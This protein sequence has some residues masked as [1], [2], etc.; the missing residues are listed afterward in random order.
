[1]N[2]SF[3]APEKSNFVLNS[4]KQANDRQYIRVNRY[5]FLYLLNLY[6]LCMFIELRGMAQEG[7]FRISGNAR[8]IDKLKSSFDS[9]GDAPLEHEADI[10]SAAG[11]LK[12]YFRYDCGLV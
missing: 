9:Q 5:C 2:I 8:L 12:T 11:L 4:K 1:M 3:V 7:L 6:R 10:A